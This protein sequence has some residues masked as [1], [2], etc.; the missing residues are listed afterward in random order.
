MY[1]FTLAGDCGKTIGSLDRLSLPL[2]VLASNSSFVVDMRKLTFVHPVGLVGLLALIE[3][4][5]RADKE[6]EIKLPGSASV[7]DYL[8][9]TNFLG[10]LRSIR[11]ISVSK[12][13]AARMAKPA[14]LT[15]ILPIRYVNSE[16]AVEELGTYVTSAMPAGSAVAGLYWPCYTVIGELALNA[17]QHG[18]PPGG[19]WA[20]AQYYEYMGGARLELAVADAGIG[21]RQSLRKNPKFVHI[22]ND[23]IAIRQALKERVSRFSSPLRGSGLYQALSELDTKGRS[24]LIRSGSGCI[25][26]TGQGRRRSSTRS[27]LVGVLAEAWI[28]A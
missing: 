11:P 4:I 19:C 26:V 28:P 12:A 25:E 2:G 6:L 3:R 21:I 14:G 16:T 20:M 9:A 18:G 1:T 13:L 23:R 8:A 10:A 22:P 17:V 27:R 24:L 7:M 5:L 15:T